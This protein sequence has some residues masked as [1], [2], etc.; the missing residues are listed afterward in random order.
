MGHSWSRNGSGSGIGQYWN[1]DEM[2]LVGDKGQKGGDLNQQ[3]VSGGNSHKRQR[4]KVGM[5]TGGVAGGGGL[6]Q[7]DCTV[8][9]VV[10]LCFGE[11]D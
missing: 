7:R 9:L 4:N 8:K 6:V 10:I 1:D 5:G 2:E 11:N 3:G